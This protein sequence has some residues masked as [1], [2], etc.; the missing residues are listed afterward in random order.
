[1]IIVSIS[2]DLIATLNSI[3]DVKYH[4]I[5]RFPM[6]HVYNKVK[7]KQTLFDRFRLVINNHTVMS[8]SFKL[9]ESEF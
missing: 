5:D 4:F 3:S 1:M 8:F 6:G 2:P 7:D 9:Y